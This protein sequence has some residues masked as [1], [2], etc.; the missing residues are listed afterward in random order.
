MNAEMILE[1]MTG[2]LHGAEQ[3]LI[4]FQFIVLRVAH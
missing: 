3:S 1:A 4:C 2:K